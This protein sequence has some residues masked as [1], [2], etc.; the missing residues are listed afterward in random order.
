M[1]GLRARVLAVCLVAGALGCGEHTHEV[2][3]YV[4]EPGQPLGAHAATVGPFRIRTAIS[5]RSSR[6]A[7]STTV[8]TDSQGS[9]GGPYS[10]HLVGSYYGQTREAW[11]LSEVTMQIGSE[12]PVLL[13]SREQ[14]AVEVPFEPWLEHAISG[15][16]VIPLGD[17]LPFQ[18]DH[19]VT[20]SVTFQAPGSD[21]PRALST[22]FVGRARSSKTSKLDSLMR[23]S[24]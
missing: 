18:T 9:L 4:L 19:G 23:G 21:E 5:G 10:L 24:L 3:D 7:E 22:T 16:H 11:R 12:P 13:H 8:F 14:P 2:Q 15:S 20:F 1:K 6:S 17:R